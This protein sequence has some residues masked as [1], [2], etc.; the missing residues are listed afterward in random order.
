VKGAKPGY[1]LQVDIID[2]HPTGWGWTGI[3]PGLG[4]LSD[5]FHDPYIKHWD[6]SDGKTT[7]LKPGIRIPIEPFCGAMG[8]APKE[9]GEFHIRPPGCFGGNIDIRHL[10]KGSTL[11]LPVQVEG[12]MFSAGDCH[13]A[14]GDGEVCVTG[15]ESPTRFTLRLTIRK[16]LKIAEPQFICNKPINRKVDAKGYYCTTGIGTEPVLKCTENHPLHD[17]APGRSI[18]SYSR[19]SLYSVQYCC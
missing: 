17:S 8:V 14:Q 4:L 6:L 15:I 16:D 19:G 13:A 7:E 3:I 12:A 18:W 10:T 2:L 1:V 5:D 9:C 11:F